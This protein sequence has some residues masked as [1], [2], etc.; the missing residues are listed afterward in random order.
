MVFSLSVFCSV[1]FPN[2]NVCS[3]SLEGSRGGVVSAENGARGTGG[4]WN[5]PAPSSSSW[6]A[7]CLLAS[8]TPACVGLSPTPV[9]HLSSALEPAVAPAVSG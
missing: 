9:R 3:Q 4:P 8:A 7:A 5:P 6:G 2:S 1:S